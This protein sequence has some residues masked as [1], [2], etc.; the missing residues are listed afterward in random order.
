M[1]AALRAPA[2]PLYGG[3]ARGQQRLLRALLRE[4]APANPET[5][6]LILSTADAYHDFLDGVGGP[7]HVHHWGAQENPYFGY[8]ALADRIVITGESVSMLA[9]ANVTGK[10]LLIYDIAERPAP[11]MPPWQRLAIRLSYRSLRDLF[12]RTI[13]APHMQ[14]DIGA[15]QRHLV[16]IGRAQWLDEAS[17]GSAASQQPWHAPRLDAQRAASRVQP[18]WNSDSAARDARAGASRR[19]QLRPALRVT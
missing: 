12:A 3:A 19:C 9:E 16:S 5:V 8:L 13:G 10:P 1:G 14:R 7:R 4:G 17:F 2:A 18:P 6:T 11:D 15:I